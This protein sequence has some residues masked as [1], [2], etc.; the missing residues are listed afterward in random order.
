MP[1]MRRFDGK[2][3]REKGFSFTKKGANKKAAS[4]RKKGM[5]VR[6]VKL[7]PLGET[8]YVLYGRTRK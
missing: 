3:Y 6:V 2:I 5:K 1:P 8:Q 7:K 4:L